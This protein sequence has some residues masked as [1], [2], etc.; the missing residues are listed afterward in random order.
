VS[1][2]GVLIG[3]YDGYADIWPICAELFA[4]FWPDRSWPMY[5]MRKARQVP[6]IATPVQIPIVN[7]RQRGIAIE[8]ALAKMPEPF[9]LFWNE[10]VFPLSPIPN[11]LFLE[12]AEHLRAN[13]DVGIVHLARYYYSDTSN[14]TH[15]N[16][17]EYPRDTIGRCSAMPAIFR[18]EILLH[19]VRALV[20]P[21]LF[22]QQSASVLLR[23]FPN[24]SVLT[25]CKPMFRLCDNPLIA[26]VWT[27]CAKKHLGELGIH[28]DYSVRGMI[29]HE[30]DYMEGVPA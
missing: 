1:D 22:E 29:E 25:S 21:N 11:D 23:D 6:D 18:K 3:T 2:V 30:S 16:F 17:K 24:M 14:P 28:A 12:A 27:Q 9:V 4:R 8:S 15:G 13:P 5:W 19:L 26:G 20:A 7:R 10:E